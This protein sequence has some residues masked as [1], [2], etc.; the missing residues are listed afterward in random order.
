M[1]RVAVADDSPTL[2][3]FVLR[4]LEETG[5]IQVCGLAGDGR[6]AVRAVRKHR[7]DVAVID[8][9][10][11][12]TDGL[13]AVREIMSEEPCPIVIF[14][15]QG[16]AVS[17][18]AG[19][20]ALS[21]GAVVLVAKPV[22]SDLEAA[23]SELIRAVLVAAE[24]KVISRRGS[25]PRRAPTRPLA[26]APRRAPRA[27]SLI[28]VGAS[29]GGPSA[30][31]EFLS[32]FPA[33]FPARFF[34]VQ[35]MARGFQSSFAAWLGSQTELE[36]EIA[37]P[38][39]ARPGVVHIAPEERHLTYT[40]EQLELRGS[41]PRGGHRPAVDVLFESLA[42]Y[43]ERALGV[44]LTGMGSD[45]AQGLLSMRR[46]GA[47]TWVQSEESCVVFGMPK[48]AI[49]LGAACAPLAPREI[50]LRIRSALS[51]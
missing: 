6:G 31:A 51:G 14:C 8:L 26:P 39:R 42:E 23:E 2:R 29:T 36:V 13:W 46:A 16:S 25:R 38:G 15:A 32:V 9:S 3:R 40:A 41:E 10:M 20:E 5:K 1:I 34:L 35:H 22:G 28:G 21:A 11:P 50:G 27:S 43:G 12:G 4:T 24:A 37:S 48:A 49:E 47:K 30:L 33:D 45:G 44:L 19:L 17:R 18:Q 7:P